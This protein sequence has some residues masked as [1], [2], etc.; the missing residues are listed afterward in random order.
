[1]FIKPAREGTGMGMGPRSIVHTESELRERVAWVI[2]TYKQPALVEE[3]LSGREF[4]VGFIGNPGFPGM[5]SWPTLYNFDGYHFFPVLEIDTG[6]CVTP[7]VY[8]YKAKSLYLEK[9]GAPGYLCPADIPAGLRDQLYALT[10]E[11][12]EAIGVCD[13]ARVDFRLDADGN[14]FMLEI[15]TLPGLNQELSDLC[16]MAQAEGISYYLLI[17]EILYLAAERFQLPTPSVSAS[18][19]LLMTALRQLEPALVAR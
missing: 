13:V 7:G 17:T 16:I 8:G 18:R 4:T 10:K 19:L 11:A 12:A 1:M 9:T 2:E 15:N 5:R 6:R 3:F 14:P